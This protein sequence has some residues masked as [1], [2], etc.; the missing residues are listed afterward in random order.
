MKTIREVSEATGISRFTLQQAAK[1]GRIPAYQSG[2]T[3]IIKTE[4]KEYQDWL[5]AYWLQPRVKG[6]QTQ[7]TEQPQITKRKTFSD[8]MFFARQIAMQVAD[9]WLKSDHPD[10]HG[11]VEAAREIERR[12]R[13]ATDDKEEITHA[14]STRD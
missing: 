3:W 11:G 4:T 5:S 10:W 2:S 8:G 12:L 9:E 1:A 6:R 7:K 13:E 14:D